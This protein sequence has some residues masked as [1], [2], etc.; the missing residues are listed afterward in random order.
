MCRRSVFSIFFRFAPFS[1]LT[2]LSGKFSECIQTTPFLTTHHKILGTELRT[3]EVCVGEG[4]G[5]PSLWTFHSFPIKEIWKCFKNIQS[6][7]R[8]QTPNYLLLSLPCYGSL[9]CF[10]PFYTSEKTRYITDRPG[11][12]GPAREF[13][14]HAYTRR[15]RSQDSPP[16]WEELEVQMR[17]TRPGVF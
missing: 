4:G 16:A 17:E 8:T 3:K 15:C 14:R 13:H 12:S 7:E 9:R 6:S 10:S 1:A 2:P 5:P 11:L